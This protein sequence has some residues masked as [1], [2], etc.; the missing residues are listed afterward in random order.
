[1]LYVRARAR[2]RAALKRTPTASTLFDRQDNREALSDKKYVPRGSIEPSF[3]VPSTVCGLSV[4]KT[5]ALCKKQ[6]VLRHE[7]AGRRNDWKENETLTVYV[8][9][10][11]NSTMYRQILWRGAS[12]TR[13]YDVLPGKAS[14]TS[15]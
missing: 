15:T 2:A 13:L 14:T 3:E 9:V 8:V 7:R 4:R 1:M 5:N 10:E 6:V 12:E 11:A